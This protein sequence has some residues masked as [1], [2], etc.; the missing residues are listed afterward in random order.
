M[1]YL[2]IWYK[3][4]LE[5]LRNRKALRDTLL[6]PLVLGV[7]YAVLN[8]MLGQMINRRSESVIVLPVQGLEYADPAFVETFA[9]YNIVLEPFAGDMETA[10]R[11]ARE[12]AG[13]IFTEGFS[14]NVASEADANLILYMNPTA[15]GPF[16]GNI[17]LSRIELALST[18]N[19]QLTVQ[20]LQVRG[21]D[22]EVLTP[23]RLTAEDLSTAAQRAGATAALFLPMLVA[24]GAINGGAF[25][26][27][28]ATAGEKER[29]T[30]EA[31]L[32]TPASDVQIF[33]GK[34]LAVFTVTA[35]PIALTL[36][37]FWAGTAFLPASM[38]GGVG[39]LP[40]DVIVKAILIT[41]PLALFANVLL[42][43]LSIRTKG[44]K[45]AQSAMTPVTFGVIFVAMA[46]AFVPPTQNVLFLIPI[47]GTSA[48]VGVLAQSGVIPA[49]AI[50]FSV[51]G[52]IAATAVITVIA[53]RLFNR[54]RLLYSM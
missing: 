6:I 23:V 4:I 27:I 2:N 14:E 9:A 12:T 30:L 28:D 31:L 37:G 26:A 16:G 46:A 40:L 25:I 35:V 41:L 45:E 38:T 34:L 15:G 24:I 22:P 49:N 50:L 43:I 10:V 39:P 17:S 47:Y 44:F 13:I 48:V 51:V 21:V 29:G 18:Y 7:F 32:I 54:E 8:P 3:E 53:L 5:M 11:E 36:L 52:S 1:N 20:R 42:M 33:V 19:Q